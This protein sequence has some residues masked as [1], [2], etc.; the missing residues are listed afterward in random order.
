MSI[1]SE[2][3]RNDYI[4]N[5]ATSV[6]PYT[7][8]IIDEEDLRVTVRDEVGEEEELVLDVDY[9]VS[10]AGGSSGG[11]IALLG[12]D[13]EED[14]AITLRRV[15]D[16]V[17]ETDFK[18]QG[19]YYPENH[20]NAFDRVVMIL[21]R[22]VDELDRS[23]KLPETEDGSSEAVNL[24]A[25]ADRAGKV[26]AFDDDGNAVPASV[27]A[28]VFTYQDLTPLAT[29]PTPAAGRIYFSSTDG[30]FYGCKDGAS[31]SLLG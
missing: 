12:G 15:P 25:A 29:A 24:P 5:G 20:E 3:S 28:S 27:P 21:Q 9:T 8:R 18:N 30:Q 4:G 10:G 17:Q 16:V 31:W 14:F 6:Y 26:L 2:N 1:S 23:I 11:S 7:F 19:R 13:L 22:L